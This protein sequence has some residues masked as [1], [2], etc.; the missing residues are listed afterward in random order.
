MSENLLLDGKD[1]G[2]LRCWRAL[3]PQ[4]A[5]VEGWEWVRVSSL[6]PAEMRPRLSRPLAGT[7]RVVPY[8]DRLRVQQHARG[9]RSAED[10]RFGGPEPF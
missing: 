4:I 5:N 6:Q 3:L 7:P 8:F 10:A 2:D 1:L 9:A